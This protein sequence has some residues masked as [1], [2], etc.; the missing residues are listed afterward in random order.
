MGI[1][2]TAYRYQVRKGADEEI[3]KAADAAYATEFIMQLRD[4]FDTMIGEL[5]GRLSGGQKQRI[6]IARALY[7]QP[8]ILLMD[9]AT[10]H[11]DPDCERQVSNNISQLPIT[12]IIVAHRRET[13][14]TANRV[15][16]LGGTNHPATARPDSRGL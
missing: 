7:R 6:C 14:A 10:S 1:S 3:R 2:R 8:S 11:L 4:G 13:I 9:E 15:I 16:D 12:R 5:G